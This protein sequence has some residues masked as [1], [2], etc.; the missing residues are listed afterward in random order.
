MVAD[1]LSR[2]NN[3]GEEIPVDDHFPNEHLFFVSIES[4][5]FADIANYLFTRKTPPHLSTPEKQSI[6]QKSVAYSWVQGDLFY[7]RP[8]LIIRKI[9]KRGR[10]V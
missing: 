5:W 9:C 4:S 10:S 8:D 1:F 2:L 6:I 7:T 3:P